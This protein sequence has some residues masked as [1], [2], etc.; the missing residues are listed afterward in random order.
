MM[1][2]RPL[3]L[4]TTFLA[5]VGLGLIVIGFLMAVPPASRTAVAFLDLLVLSLVYLVLLFTRPLNW[6]ST[7]AFSREIPALGV[8]LA[9]HSSY[10]I[11]SIG[12]IW[13]GWIADIPF[14]FQLWYHLAVTFVF[15]VFL[16]IAGRASEY[17]ESVA[18]VEQRRTDS[19]QT[20]KGAISECDAA[21]SRLG[22]EWASEY[23]IFQRIKDDVRYLSPCDA[24]NAVSLDLEISWALGELSAAI[25]A[26]AQLGGAGQR[27]LP[28]VMDHQSVRGI[29][30]RCQALVRLRK[31]ER[32]Q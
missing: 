32:Q 24:V 8:L 15:L 13:Y 1:G 17:A 3:T 11:L 19:L 28:V 26:P 30:T 7:E 20:V 31:Q 27:D 16:T 2:R 25:S 21:F 22:G 23:S 4:P 29:L 14:R 12:G 5:R 9:L 10:A 18:T 6:P